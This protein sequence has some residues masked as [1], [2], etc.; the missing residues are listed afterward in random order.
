MGI[1]SDDWYHDVLGRFEQG[2]GLWYFFGTYSEF[3]SSCW[4]MW[5]NKRWGLICSYLFLRHNQT[6]NSVYHVLYTSHRQTRARSWLIY[7]HERV[8]DYTV[9]MWMDGLNIERVG[10]FNSPTPDWMIAPAITE[11]SEVSISQPP[12]S[13]QGQRPL[14]HNHRGR[15]SPYEK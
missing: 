6:S 10:E 13:P 2:L 4:D 14:L 7:A 9:V 3:S 8:L 12:R 1:F 5:D 11:R 15:L